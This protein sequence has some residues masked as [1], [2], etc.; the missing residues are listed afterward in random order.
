VS[1]DRFLEKNSQHAGVEERCSN[2]KCRRVLKDIKY[3]LTVRGK[4]GVYCQL[5]AKQILRP[6]ENTE[7]NL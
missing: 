5:C 2:P 3:T 7:E 6:Q 1:L 4:E